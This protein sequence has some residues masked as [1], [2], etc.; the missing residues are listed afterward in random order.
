MVIVQVVVS[1][2]FEF[3]VVCSQKPWVGLWAVSRVGVQS[4]HNAQSV[5]RTTGHLEPNDVPHNPTTDTLIR[6]AM[7]RTVSKKA[8]TRGEDLDRR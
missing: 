4:V 3:S 1:P 2:L 5:L 6:S 8:L 7:M